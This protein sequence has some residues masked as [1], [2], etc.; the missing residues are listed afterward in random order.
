MSKIEVEYSNIEICL[1]QLN[2]KDA[3]LFQGENA[4]FTK[5][6]IKSNRKF[7]HIRTCEFN[8]LIKSRIGLLI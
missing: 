3:L 6:I 4:N 8:K 5:E 1:K 7:N 2:K